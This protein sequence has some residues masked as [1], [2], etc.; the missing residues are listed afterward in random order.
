M[1]T[2]VF[3]CLVYSSILGLRAK[4]AHSKCSLVSEWMNKMVSSHSPHLDNSRLSRRFY[5]L[6]KLL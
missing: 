6:R 2:R 3:V 1:R 4:L 5:F